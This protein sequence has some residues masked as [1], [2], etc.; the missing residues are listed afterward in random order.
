MHNRFGFAVRAYFNEFLIL[1]Q[2][3][4][5]VVRCFYIVFIYAGYTYNFAGKRSV[6]KILE[7]NPLKKKLFRVFS[8]Y[9]A[10][11]FSLFFSE[12]IYPPS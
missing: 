8:A 12:R 5:V 3:L 2:A 11:I 6:M 4:L 7:K 9:S 1:F 10:S